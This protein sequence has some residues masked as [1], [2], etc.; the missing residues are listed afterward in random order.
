MD[1]ELAATPTRNGSTMN[2]IRF[3]KHII[4]TTLP[5]R[6]Y[7]QTALCD[8][9]GD[10]RLEYVVGRQFGEIYVYQCH[11]PDNWTRHRVAQDSPSD[12]GLATL[13]VTGNG[14]PDLITGGAWY[15]NSGDLRRPFERIV[16][17]PDLKAVHDI[18]IADINHDGRPEVLTMSDKNTVRW[19]A[20]PDDPRQPWVRHDIGAGVHA[21]L[22]V[23]D[24]T[25]NGHLDVVRTNVW[26]ENVNGD[27]STWREHDVGPC[28]PPPADY[29]HPWAFNATRCRVVDINGDGHND[30]VFTDAEIPG[31]RI[32]W[33]E[34]LDGRGQR[35]QRHEIHDGQNPRGGALH[36]LE[37]MDFDGDG[38]WDVFSAEMEFV[39]GERSPRWS[40]WENV[41]GRGGQWRQ[42]VLLDENLGGHEVVVG[43]VQGNGRPDMI[44]KP[45]APH[46]GNAA[47]GNMFVVF[48]ENI[49]DDT[50]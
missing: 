31:S 30:L 46:S 10:G 48:L 49:T 33:M 28:T 21:G 23:G 40:I 4:D 12:V 42:H 26:F 16:F 22:A 38:D 43:D 1:R 24:L 47:N 25:G 27:G 50:D 7:A 17:D 8:L 39:R 13:D 14:L 11:S 18:M 6:F 35:W 44:G 34:N 37:V 29:Q 3:R 45:W 32:W 36:S 19:Y 20:I 5:G 2:N 9:T 41:D 15:R